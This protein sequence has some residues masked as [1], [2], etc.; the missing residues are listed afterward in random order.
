MIETASNIYP[1]YPIHRLD[2]NYFMIL[3]IEVFGCVFVLSRCFLNLSLGVGTFAI[4]LSQITS[5]S[6]TCTFVIGTELSSLIPNKT[7]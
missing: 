7:K 2:I 1:I 5:F 6:H 4:G 3:V